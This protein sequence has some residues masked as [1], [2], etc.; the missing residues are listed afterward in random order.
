MDDATTTIF[1]TCGSDDSQHDE[2]RVGDMLHDLRYEPIP[3]RRCNGEV[4]ASDLN[5]SHQALLDGRHNHNGYALVAFVRQTNRCTVKDQHGTES[6]MTLCID[7]FGHC[8]AMDIGFGS[9]TSSATPW[10]S[11]GRRACVDRSRGSGRVRSRLDHARRE[12]E[13]IDAPTSFLTMSFHLSVAGQL[14]LNS[15][16]KG[17]RV[18][19]GRIGPVTRRDPLY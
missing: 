10:A 16:L 19:P 15:K 14:Q 5:S 6:Y 8:D 3:K 17:S 13:C 2:G 11:T 12:S 18:R 9:L 7:V 4:N 1:G